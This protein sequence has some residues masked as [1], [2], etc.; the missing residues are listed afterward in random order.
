MRADDPCALHPGTRTSRDPLAVTPAPARPAGTGTTAGPGDGPP[1]S[2]ERSVARV[3]DAGNCSGCGACTLLDPGLTMRLDPEGFIRPVPV[4]SG[5]RPVASRA[6][7]RAFRAACPGRRVRAQRPAGS[8]RDPQLGPVVAVWEA[9]AVDPE[10]R[11]RG[12]SGGTLTALAAWLAETGQAAQVV[13]ARSDADE[14]RRT[15]PVRITTRADALTSAGSRYAPVATAGHPAATDPGGAVIG[16]PCEVAALRALPTAGHGGARPLLLSFFCAGVPSQHATSDLLTALGVPQG[17][18]LQSLRYRGH[19]WPG[20][21]T[22][23]TR[24]GRQVRASYD[25]SWGRH[26]G[27]AVQWRCKIC[28]DGVGE[29]A[30][31]AAGD[32]WRSDDR[33]Y[34]DFTEG[35]GVSVLVARTERGRATVER[36]V[37]AGVLEV[38]PITAGSVAAVQPLQV[39]RRATLLGRLLGARLAGRPVPS[40][41]GFGLL[42]L[43]SG[44][45]RE[46]V[47]TARGTHRR[48][49]DRRDGPAAGTAG[50]PRPIG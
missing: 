32:Y 27:P 19:G 37:A 42:R 48:S 24:A 39:R 31:I 30:D 38:R 28:P 1:G 13:G 23:V 10:I 5:P 12:S 7:E 40:V 49:R 2:L 34:P 43:A 15:V 41:R 50:R 6:Q 29:S 25:E 33:G 22:A 45:P 11:H 14:P 36:A 18:E 17:E 8:R 46:T 4:G 9:W 44:Q 20:E 35:S 16:R 47:R 3:V 21:F 26:L